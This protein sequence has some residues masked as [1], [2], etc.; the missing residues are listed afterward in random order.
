MA[1]AC[2]TRCSAG[3]DFADEEF[4]NYTLTLPAGVGAEQERSAH[5]GRHAR[6][7]APA[8][9]EALRVAGLNRTFVAK[10]LGVYAQDLVEVAPDWKLLAG[11]RW[12]Q[13]RRR[14]RQPVAIPATRLAR[15]PASRSRLALEPAAS[16][17]STSRPTTSSYYASY[18]TSFNT[19]GELYNYDPPG[20][21]APP[22]KSRNIELG[23]KLDAVR[24][25]LVDRLA[26]FH[27]TKYNERNRD[28]PE[29][30]P[31]VDFILSGERHAAGLELDLAGRITP[32]LGGVP[33]RTPGSRAPRSTRRPPASR[34]A[35]SA[36]ATG[37]R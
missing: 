22:E 34:R 37:R 2:S 18:G 12:D 23:A 25:P 10:A 28:S 8:V 15:R 27:A 26:L 14:L 31:I 16:A 36:R 33:A 29:G 19:S 1:R 21:N 30:Q 6:T 35:A 13:L 9:D 17:C 11:L 5:H 32:A 20:S 7:T 4:K 24:R 3:V